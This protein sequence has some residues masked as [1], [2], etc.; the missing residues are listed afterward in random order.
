MAS[1]RRVAGVIL[2]SPFTSAMRVITDSRLLACF[3][4]FPNI[5]RISNVQAPVFIIHGAARGGAR[6]RGKLHS[7]THRPTP[8]GQEDE[9]VPFDHGKTLHEACPKD[10]RHEPWWVPG[11]SHNDIVEVEP[12]EY[13]RRLQRFIRSLQA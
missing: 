9:E 7:F 4:M 10:L 1:R 12:D 5:D 8:A 6:G 13:F 3:D 11:A 2:H